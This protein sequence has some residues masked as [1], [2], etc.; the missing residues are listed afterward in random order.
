MT[1]FKVQRVLAVD[2][3]DKGFA[4]AILD[5]PAVLVDWGLKRGKEKSKYRERATALIRRY[6][7]DVLIAER[8]SAP[9][10]RRRVR[11]RRMIRQLLALAR[12]H[13][14]RAYQISRKSVLRCF[15]PD[16]AINKHN[17]AVAL[18]ER[19]PELQSRLPPMRKLWKPERERMGIFDAVA[20][21][22]TSY[23]SWRKERRAL[24][25]LEEDNPLRDA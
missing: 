4:Y 5:G 24:A 25:L 10:C 17:I 20:F 8:A 9:S 7:P 21:G 6:Q 3:T 22:W 23:E 16:S 18:A 15:S 11:A 14:L 19:F 2:P 12:R 13:H 1:N